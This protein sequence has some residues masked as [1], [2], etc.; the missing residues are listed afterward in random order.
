[1]GFTIYY[2]STRP[3]DL[4]ESAAI[5]VAARAA[6]EGRM[7]F[8]CE[9]VHFFPD[10]DGLL[11][12]GSK[13]NF[14]PHPGAKVA[15]CEGLPNG[16][17]RDML[18]ILCGLSRDHGIDWEIS[19][20]HSGGPIGYIRAGVCDSTVLSQLEAFTDLSAALTDGT[21]LAFE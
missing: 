3:V 15:A 8:G 14:L 1:M 10:D 20:D 4:M 18:D 12:G 11:V 6:N 9:P 5:C 7:W 21:D 13:P 17:T 19:H 16:T 2:R